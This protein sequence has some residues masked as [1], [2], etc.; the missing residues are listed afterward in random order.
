MKRSRT[1]LF[2]DENIQPD[3]KIEVKED[4]NL[5]LRLSTHFYSRQNDSMCE[6][7]RPTEISQLN[8]DKCLNCKLLNTEGA[9]F[10]QNCGNILMNDRN[11]LAS[12]QSDVDITNNAGGP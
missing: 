2:P 6:P 9:K 5:L 12:F 7:I 11:T 1:Y 4:Q 3:Q 8:P 10:C